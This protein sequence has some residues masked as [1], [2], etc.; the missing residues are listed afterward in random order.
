M[1]VTRD[2]L[3]TYKG[4][5]QVVS[6]RLAM[7]IREDRG[8][9]VLMAACVTIFIA[10]WPRLA[11]EAH[12]SGQELNMMLGGSLLVWVFI[13]PLAFMCSRS[14]FRRFCVW[15]EGRSMGFRAGSRCSGRFWRSRRSRYSAGLSVVSL[16][17]VLSM[18]ALV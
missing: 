15:L 5:G 2:I 14:S 7:G 17:R 12:L 13:M 8:L 10:Q 9:A 18:T 6:R 4:P 16:G 1:S 11:R 3:A